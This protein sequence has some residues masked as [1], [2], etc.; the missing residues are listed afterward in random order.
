ME[1]AALLE[2]DVSVHLYNGDPGPGVQPPELFSS[3]S[4]Q[5]EFG[6]RLFCGAETRKSCT[7]YLGD[8]KDWK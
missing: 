4:G 5:L 2:D 7:G 3:R 8:E 6:E 1:P